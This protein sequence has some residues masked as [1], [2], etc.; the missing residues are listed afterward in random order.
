MTRS[1]TTIVAISNPVDDVSLN[2]KQCSTHLLFLDDK[3]MDICKLKCKDIYNILLSKN[4]YELQPFRQ[5]M[6]ELYNLTDDHWKTLYTTPYYITTCTKIRAF[7][8]RLTHGLLYGNKQLCRFGYKEESNCFL[9]TTPLQTFQHLLI[10]CPFIAK[11]WQD[12]EN[13]FG[14]IIDQPITNI[15]KELGCLDENDE[16]FV[17]KNLLLIITRLYIYQCNME[18]SIPSLMGLTCKLRY[19]ERIEYDIEMRKNS[20]DNHF[21]KWENILNSLAHGIPL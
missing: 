13:E 1:G 19:Y 14:N 16:Y 12:I 6:T 4:K 8:F 20:V 11:L 9:C 3:T 18:E 17:D 21:I 15:E 5:R 10:D 7:H 2:N